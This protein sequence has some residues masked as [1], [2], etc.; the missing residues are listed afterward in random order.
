MKVKRPLR[1]PVGFTPFALPGTPSFYG[2][3]SRIVAKEF[4]EIQAQAQARAQA[5]AQAQGQAHSHAALRRC[6]TYQVVDVVLELG[7]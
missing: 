2:A 3:W 6:G 1:F 5:Q 7:A 4:L